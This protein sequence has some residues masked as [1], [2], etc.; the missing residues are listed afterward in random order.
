MDRQTT[1]FFEIF[2]RLPRQGPGDPGS[3]RRALELITVET[4]IRSVL[5]LGCGTGAQTLTLARAEP[6]CRIV[7]ID[8]HEPFVR[9]LRRHAEAAGVGD[10][11]DA[12]V[13]DMRTPDIGSERFDVV[14]CEGAI[15]N[16]GVEA[17]LRAWREWLVPG[18]CV[19][20]TDA[21][22][23]R[24][25]PPAEC[26]AFWAQEYP[27]IGEV[28]ALV[29]LVGACG[30]ELA[31]HFPLPREAWWDNYYAPL[32][33]RLEE[34]RAR[35]PGEDSE[36]AGVAAAVQREIDIWRACGE[37]YQYEFFVARRR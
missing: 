2:D 3:T 28:D 15:Y 31:G 36:A 33:Q 10:R 5:D 23:S 14:W 30:Y 27:A 29:A 18:G 7:A 17:G 22:W 37:S 24:P 16:V 21:C 6:A 26:A 20:F 32:Q 8:N 12:R 35:Y 34:F 1:L 4:R 9:E 25:D 13:G 11:V 19:A